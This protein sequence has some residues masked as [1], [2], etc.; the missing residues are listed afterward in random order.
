MIQT[1]P[2]AAPFF[3]CSGKQ[4][5]R[6]LPGFMSFVPKIDDPVKA[7]AGHLKPTPSDIWGLHQVLREEMPP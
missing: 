6:D 1:A 3:G 5:S 4:A 2:G 7:K